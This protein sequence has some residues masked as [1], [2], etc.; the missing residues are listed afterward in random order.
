MWKNEGIE[1]GRENEARE[2]AKRMIKD[3]EM[4]LEKI[5]CYLPSL[6]MDELMEIEA[7]VIRLT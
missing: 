3:R 5:A 1:I 2:T 7:E 6:A 4:S